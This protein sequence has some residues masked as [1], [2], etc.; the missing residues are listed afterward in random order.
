MNAK[1]SSA[2]GII[3]LVAATA[4][5]CLPAAADTP[6][7]GRG[8]QGAAPTAVPAGTSCSGISNSSGNPASGIPAGAVGILVQRFVPTA[9]P[10]RPSAVCI[11]GFSNN[12]SPAAY[13]VVIFSDLNGMPGTLLAT[14]PATPAAPGTFPGSWM[15]TSVAGL[16]PFLYGPVWAGPRI[17]ADVQFAMD[18]DAATAPTIQVLLP[19]DATDGSAAIPFSGGIAEIQVAGL[20]TADAPIPALSGIGLAALAAALATGGFLA[21]RRA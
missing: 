4:V 20:S 19:P 21:I 6:F 2:L 8:T 13:D 3:C 11:A 16:V 9:Y 15:T 1:R 14:I 17:T 5:V 7:S 12:A 10:F 18:F